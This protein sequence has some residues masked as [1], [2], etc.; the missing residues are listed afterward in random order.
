MEAPFKDWYA[1]AGVG[2][3]YIGCHI[4]KEDAEKQAIREINVHH[5]KRGYCIVNKQV[6]E[7]IYT[8]IK[9]CL[10]RDKIN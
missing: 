3:W 1:I 6:L 4:N 10:D 5:S 7:S 2:C 8:S 9:G